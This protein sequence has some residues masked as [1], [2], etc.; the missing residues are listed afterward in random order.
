MAA[1]SPQAM[2]LRVV[3]PDRARKLKLSSRPA[4]VD[5]L[6]AVIKEQLEIDLD[7]SLK[8]EDPDFDG[9]LTSLSDIDELPQKAVVHVSFEQDSSSVASTETMSSVSSSERGRR[10]PSH[11]F[12]IPTFSFDVE[13]RLRE[14]NAEFEKNNKQLQLTRDIK[15]DILE[16]LASVMYGYKAYP[17]DKEIAMVA[18]ALVVKHPC[19]KE[20]GSQTGWNGWKNSLKFKMGNYRSKM[21]RAGCP[22]I[23]VNAG[24]R[25]AMNPDNESSHSNIKRPKRAEVNFLPNF[26]QGE[27]PSTLEQLR[28][29]I[30]DE[31]KKAEKNLPLI[32]KMMQT[33]FA[34]RRQTIVK[35][36]PPV[37]EL[38][39]LW[40]ALKMESE[41]YAEFQRIT[42]ENLPNTFYSEL[43]RHLPRLMTLFRQ[44]ASRTG[45]TSDT[46]TEILRIH[47]DQEFHDIHTK[48]VTVLHALPVYLREDVSG[49]L[50][51]CM[52]TS[53]EPELL[54]VAVALLTV[55]KDNDTSPV[56]FQP[57][58]ISVV[59]EIEIVGS[60]SRFA[61]AFLVMFGLI[62]ALHLNYPRG[63]T[64]TFEFIQKILLGLDEGKLSPKLQSLKNDLMC[65]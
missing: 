52:D 41:V 60:L 8:Y 39:E 2:I 12:P 25:S 63:L 33:T 15:H 24:K 35:T 61:D 6:I 3:E 49:F 10:W 31:M 65:M 14:G 47:D 17:S 55:I 1:L 11:I 34:L 29:K 44:K 7:F 4:S 54:D 36:C 38:M 46:L 53:D 43:D 59:I 37:K 48:R 28:Q 50:R 40:P 19:L 18:E 9:K 13:L 45:K 57:V 22:E 62:Y 26:P 42:N 5:A 16:K 56:H 64:N 51:T 27:N 32:K 20:A 30:V 21:R 23:T 58:K